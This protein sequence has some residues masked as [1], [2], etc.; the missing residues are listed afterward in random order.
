MSAQPQ[1][2][3]PAVQLPLADDITEPRGAEILIEALLHEGVDAIFGYPGGAVLHI[4]DEL[5]RGGARLTPHLGRHVRGAGEMAGGYG[6]TA[7]AG[8]GGF[9]D[10]RPGRH[11]PVAGDPQ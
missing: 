6:R 4:Y 10:F 8:R 7:G 5:W 2:L 9:G 11:P 3:K 1:T